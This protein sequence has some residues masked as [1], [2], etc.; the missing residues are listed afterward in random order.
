MPIFQVDVEKQQGSEYWTNVYHVVAVDIGDATSQAG[1]IVLH[2]REIH[3]D[4]VGFVKYRVGTYPISDGDF[5]LVPLS[6][7]GSRTHSGDQLALFN[8]ARVDLRLPLGRPCRK[9]YRAPIYEGD[10]ADGALTIAFRGIV[11]TAVEAMIA[12]GVNLCDPDGNLV[13]D[14]VTAV[15]VGMRQLRRGSR[16]RVTPVI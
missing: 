3:S 11:D 15:P 7:T 5:S 14:A 10:Q 13:T 9:Y 16:R 12:D 1:F 8:V 4:N 2:E 6:G